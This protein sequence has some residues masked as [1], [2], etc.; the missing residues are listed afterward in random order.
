MVHIQFAARLLEQTVHLWIG[1]AGEIKFAV[2]VKK[3]IEEVLWVGIIGAPAVKDHMP[4]LFAG[5]VIEQ[6]RVEELDIHLNIQLLAPHYDPIWRAKTVLP[7]IKSDR[8]NQAKG[9]LCLS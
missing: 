5:Y 9:L 6:L 3:D 4:G 1:I 8:F 7:L 2:T